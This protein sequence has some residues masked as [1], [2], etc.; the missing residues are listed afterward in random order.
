MRIAGLRRPG[1]DSRGADPAGD[2]VLIGSAGT[3]D[4][5]E[6]LD[7]HGVDLV[8]AARSGEVVLAGGFLADLLWAGRGVG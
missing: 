5:L 6:Q 3:K 7:V 8:T 2:Q 1:E 4:A